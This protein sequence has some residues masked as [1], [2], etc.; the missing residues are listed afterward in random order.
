MAKSSSNIYFHTHKVNR[1]EREK[2]SGH[3]GLLVWC[4]GL[5]GSGKSTV[6]G[7]LEE[8]LFELGIRTYILDGDNI[9]TGLNKDLGFSDEDRVENIRRIG[10][11]A[12]LFVDAGV[13]VITAFISPFRAERASVIENLGA[14]NVLQVYVNAPIE[15]CE[16]RDVK[17]LYA[18]ARAGEIKNFT[19]IDSPF[20]A[21]ENPDVEVHTDKE[22]LETSTSKILEKLLPKL[23]SI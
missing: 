3:K 20:E 15:V 23:K 8:K 21:P 13:V 14:E 17:G 5:S 9:R 10:E 18:K 16:Q 6:A 2:A 11:V 22:D 12:K 7:N 4:T 19:G 1:S